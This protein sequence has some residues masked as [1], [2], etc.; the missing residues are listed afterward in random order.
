MNLS[1]TRPS[2]P[3]DSFDFS[4]VAASFEE[5]IPA[6]GPSD[7]DS[8]DATDVT[9]DFASNST[10]AVHALPTQRRDRHIVRY[11]MD[12]FIVRDVCSYMSYD[13]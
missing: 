2:P 4:R 10:S 6:P 11:L 3:H 12:D 1:Q 7:N 9:T 5:G 13:D 8:R